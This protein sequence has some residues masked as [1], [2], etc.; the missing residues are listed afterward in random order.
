MADNDHLCALC[1]KLADKLALGQDKPEQ[2]KLHVG[3]LPSQ[4]GHAR[5]HATLIDAYKME[6]N[7]VPID[8]YFKIALMA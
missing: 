3:A 5:T 7:Q 1:R 8:P 2:F 4:I 6:F